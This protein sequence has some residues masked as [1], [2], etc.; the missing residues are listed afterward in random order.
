MPSTGTA[1]FTVNRDQLIDAAYRI[2][3]VVKETHSANATQIRVGAQS[4]NML[5]KNL[6]SGGLPLWTYQTLQIPLV[7]GQIT[8][9]IGPVGADVLSTRPLRLFEG[10][11]IRFPTCGNQDTPLRLI[12]RLEYLQY[13]NKSNQAIVN[14]IY[15]QPNIDDAGGTTSPSTGYGTLYV[16]PAPSDNERI[17]FGN[18]QRPIYDMSSASDEFDLPQ[19]WFRYLKFALASDLSYECDCDHARASE[20][21]DRAEQLKAE[22]FDWSTETASVTFQPSPELYYRR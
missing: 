22:L 4:L 15:Y 16:W 11:F 18:F 9:T 21:R 10:S 14:S 3:R 13:S 1:G 19:E 7:T 5:I 2:L 8:Y 20:A 12:S 17:V 6:Q